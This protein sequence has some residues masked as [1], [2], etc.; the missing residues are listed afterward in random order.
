MKKNLLTG[1]LAASAALFV[2]CSSEKDYYDPNGAVAQK[3]AQYEFAFTKRY[4]KIA[5]DQD[6]G[7]GTASSVKAVRGVDANANEWGTYVNVPDPLT[8]AQIQVVSKWFREHKTPEGIAVNW[9]DFF[10]QQVS[11]VNE[12]DNEN[13]VEGNG[14]GHMDYLTCGENNEHIYNFNNGTCSVNGNVC[15]A[16]DPDE[17]KDMNNRKLYHSDRI[18]YMVNSSTSKFGYHNSLDSKDYDDYVIIPGDMIDPSVAGM[19]FVGFDYQANGQNAN[20]Q[21][22][23]DGYYNDWIIK[24]TPGIY[25]GAYRIIVEDLGD[26]DDFDFNDVVFD[27]VFR[28]VTIITL[29]AVGGTMPLYIQVE[30]EKKEVHELFGVSSSTM[31]NTGSVSKAPVIFRLPLPSSNPSS[32]SSSKNH[33]DVQILVNDGTAVYYLKADCGKAP[34]KILV[35]TTY[36][37]TKERES[38]DTKYP[39]FAEWVSNKDAKWI[40]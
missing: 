22:K 29:Q 4:G 23:L 38:I 1:M 10:A 34:Q 13:Y 15:Y 3:E 40:K 14:H 32:N 19:Y 35:P 6:W 36:E 37:W 33:A 7:F 5:P 2:A 20:Q 27:V 24:I 17:S 30:D 39:A 11:S 25:K 12:S 16:L 8:D 28:D 18:Q 26:T 21:V 9:S 31:V